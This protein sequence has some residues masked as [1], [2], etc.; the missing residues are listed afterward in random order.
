MENEL[1]KYSL[2]LS[3]LSLL[4]SKHLVSSVEYKKIKIKLMKKYKI[5]S[6]LHL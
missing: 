5:F 1:L 6:N 2:Q 4:L 3:M